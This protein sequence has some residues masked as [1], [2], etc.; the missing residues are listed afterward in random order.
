MVG[1]GSPYASQNNVTWLPTAELRLP[2]VLVKDGDTRHK[3]KNF[4][5]ISDYQTYFAY[6]KY[7]ELRVVH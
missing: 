2:D 1:F 6:D 4:I 7:W 3:I 5:I